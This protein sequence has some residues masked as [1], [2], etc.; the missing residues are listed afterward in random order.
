[1]RFM[2]LISNVYFVIVLKQFPKFEYFIN[3]RCDRS[4]NRDMW[5]Q[6]CLRHIESPAR[7]GSCRTRHGI[8]APTY[9]ESEF[10]VD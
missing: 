2:Y 8:A 10:S 6:R 9:T 5:T 7:G 3:I 4:N 1:M